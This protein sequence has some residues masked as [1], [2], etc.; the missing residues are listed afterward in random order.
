MPSL[1]AEYGA[2][3]WSG[4][5]RIAKVSRCTATA[6][7]VAG[8]FFMENL[9]GTVI[10]TAMPKMAVSFGVACGALAL[11]AAGFFVHPAVPGGLP[12]ADFRI[13]F[14]LI[15]VISLAS[16]ADLLGLDAEAGALL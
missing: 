16:V 6:L 7:L 2:D 3:C 1:K 9:D 4:L 12:L 5:R 10:V 13:V 15:G 11:D 14:I 8:A